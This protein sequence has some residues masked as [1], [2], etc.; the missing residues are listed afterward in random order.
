MT[1]EPRKYIYRLTDIGE[2]IAD[3]AEEQ[4]SQ[5]AESIK[6]ALQLMRELGTADDY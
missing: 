2:K 6:N 4:S 1:F 5:E 3:L